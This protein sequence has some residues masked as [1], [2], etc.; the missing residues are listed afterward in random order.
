MTNI[1]QEVK[2][3]VLTVAK[4]KVAAS[5]SEDVLGQLVDSVMQHQSYSHNKDNKTFIERVVEQH[6][7]EAVRQAVKEHLAEN[8]HQINVAVKAA[9]ADKAESFA[10]SILDAFASDDWKASLNVTVERP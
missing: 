3:A 8:T 1:D 5:L 7:Q 4:A 10:T 9:M 2:E 6:I